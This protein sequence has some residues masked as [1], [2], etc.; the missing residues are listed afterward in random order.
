MTLKSW[1]NEYKVIILLNKW[2]R[3]TFN[4]F[5]GALILNASYEPIR[6]INWQKALL[7]W[8]QERVDVLDFHGFYAH[9]TS[10]S[11]QLPSILKL[12]KYINLRH[13]HGVRLTRQNAFIRDNFQCQYCLKT[14]PKKDL[15]IDHIIPLSKGG[16]NTWENVTTACHPCNN[17]KGSKSLAEF[18]KSPKNKPYQPEWL[19]NTDL[20]FKSVTTPETWKPY[21]RKIWSFILI[22]FEFSVLGFTHQLPLKPQI[23]S[24]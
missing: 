21:L 22:W 12:K 5:P 16:G 11:F 7:L 10:K 24:V 18:K 14:L 15:T 19:P 13:H 4:H 3:L 23:I 1:D 20:R 9:S 2:G 17:S 6:I 8:L